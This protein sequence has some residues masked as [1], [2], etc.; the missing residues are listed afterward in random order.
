MSYASKAAKIFNDHKVLFVMGPSLVL[1]HMAWSKLNQ[2][3]EFVPENDLREKAPP[4]VRVRP[5]YYLDLILLFHRAIADP[6]LQRRPAAAGELYIPQSS[7]PF[8][9]YF[10]TLFPCTPSQ[11]ILRRRLKV[12]DERKINCV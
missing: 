5:T 1:L 11:W 12:F 10:F 4:Y 3:P 6:T 2:N 7:W 9:P 8:S